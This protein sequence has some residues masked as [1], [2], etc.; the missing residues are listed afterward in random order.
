MEEIIKSGDIKKNIVE[1]FT[2]SLLTY[3]VLKH[4]YSVDKIVGFNYSHQFLNHIYFL[5]FVLEK[6][7]FYNIFMEDLHK[8]LKNGPIL[9][10]NCILPFSF[11]MGLGTF[12]DRNTNCLLTGQFLELNGLRFTLSTTKECNWSDI[13]G[14]REL[15]DFS[16]PLRKFLQEN[17]ENFSAIYK[18][19]YLS[20]FKEFTFRKMLLSTGE[21]IEEWFMRY[22][23]ENGY[24]LVSYDNFIDSF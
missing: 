11:Q 14:K 18:P 15:L 9:I 12:L 20:F 21:N 1:T 2:L 17:S 23:K 16:V 8:E 4:R 3:V 13:F 22:S 19:L 10:L 24:S 6:D 5:L 7:N